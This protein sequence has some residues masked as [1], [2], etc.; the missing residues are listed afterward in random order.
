LIQIIPASGSDCDKGS[1]AR[2]FLY[3][4]PVTGSQVQ[5]AVEAEPT[6]QVG[7]YE[8]YEAVECVAC[9]RLHLVNLTTLKLL[10]EEI[11]E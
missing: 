5:G 8:A 10:S 7:H 6:D 4:C 2:P 3:C 11:E 9:R 1:M